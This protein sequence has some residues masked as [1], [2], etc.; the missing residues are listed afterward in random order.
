MFT[1]LALLRTC[2]FHRSSSNYGHTGH[3]LC[4]FK[5]YKSR[6][7]VLPTLL[8][9]TMYSFSSSSVRFLVHVSA[10]LASAALGVEA[11]KRNGTTKKTHIHV[12]VGIIA[13]IVIIAVVTL[14]FCIIL[15]IYLRRRRNIRSS[16][17]RI[18][19]RR[20]KG[21]NN[22]TAAVD[23]ETELA[24]QGL[25]MPEPEHVGTDGHSN[26]WQPHNAPPPEQPQY[27][28]PV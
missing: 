16:D 5:A 27:P 14:I 15:A 28:K 1:A 22:G 2:L 23:T 9:S 6:Q 13:A 21:N 10:V 17:V 18:I 4:F 3:V 12:S 25:V 8:H 26:A 24:P 11:K 19:P 7:T 20:S